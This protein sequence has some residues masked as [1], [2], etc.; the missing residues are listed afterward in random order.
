[1]LLLRQIKVEVKKY[2]AKAKNSHGFDHVERVYNLAIH[3]GKKEKGDLEIIRYAALLHDIARAKEDESKGL[4]CHAAVGAKLA[5]K[6]LQKYKLSP[7]KISQ[8]V[9]CIE[10]HRYR[11]QKKPLTKEAKVLFD[12]DKLDSIGAI[13]IGRAFL[14]AGEVG[15]KVHNSPTI[16]VLKTT[17][18]SKEDTAYREF[19]VKLSRLKDKML[20]RE[21]KKIALERHHFMV[22][23]FEKLKNEISGK[24]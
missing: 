19:M 20:T 1:M 13:G 14:F 9:H 5:E 3:I 15:A 4:I 21:G 6:I 17:P 12:A 16:D 10:T 18:Y 2:F 7:E 22:K 24:E 8:I 23:F 11:G